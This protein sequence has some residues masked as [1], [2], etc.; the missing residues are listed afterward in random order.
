M[1]NC[2]TPKMSSL[3]LTDSIV[4]RH[5]LDMTFNMNNSN[6]TNR[7]VYTF[8]I[9]MLKEHVVVSKTSRNLKSSIT[10]NYP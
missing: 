7:R 3:L 9:N 10:L 4:L 1:L 8:V 6:Y 5:P 2:N